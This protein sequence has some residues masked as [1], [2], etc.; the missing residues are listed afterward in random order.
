MFAF[1]SAKVWRGKRIR[2]PAV[3]ESESKMENSNQNAAIGQQKV[4]EYE[5]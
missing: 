5:N 3:T 2:M 4:I 1:P